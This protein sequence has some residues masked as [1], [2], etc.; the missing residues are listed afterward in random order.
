MKPPFWLR[1]DGP[2]KDDKTGK[3]YLLARVR[4]FAWPVFFLI[5]LKEHIRGS[6]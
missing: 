3:V 1:L 4:W 6:R 5:G 2:Y